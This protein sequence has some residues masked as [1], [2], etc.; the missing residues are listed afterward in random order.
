MVMYD[1]FLDSCE[2]TSRKAALENARLSGTTVSIV[3][4]EN[5]LVQDSWQVYCPACAG[6]GTADVWCCDGDDGSAV[7][8]LK[9]VGKTFP[10]KDAIKARG[11]R[12]QDG[13]W[14]FSG[15]TTAS[16]RAEL[17]EWVGAMKGCTVYGL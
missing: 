14:L 12:W 15:T 4:L 11:F 6:Q 16:A 8:T 7:V 2:G 13:A 5:L 1:S 10:H 3:V 17:R 9:I